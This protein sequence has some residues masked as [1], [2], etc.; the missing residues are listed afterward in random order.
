M[1]VYCKPE[2]LHSFVQGVINATGTTEGVDVLPMYGRR[3]CIDHYCIRIHNHKLHAVK[4]EVTQAIHKVM[5]CWCHGEAYAYWEFLVCND[6]IGSADPIEMI[7]DYI[8][9]VGIIFHDG[10]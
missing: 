8:K 9:D 6:L 3:D 1:R 5:D 4:E 2:H 10:K 7:H